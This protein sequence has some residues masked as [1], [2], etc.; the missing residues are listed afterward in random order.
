[1]L[2]AR[3]HSQT[4][5]KGIAPNHSSG[6]LKRDSLIAAYSH[7]KRFWNDPS[8]AITITF[9]EG[10]V[11]PEEVL[12]GHL[13]IRDPNSGFL[14]SP[15]RDA[16]PDGASPRTLEC[17]AEGLAVRV[18]GSRQPRAAMTSVHFHLSLTPRRR[19]ISARVPPPCPSHKHLYATM[20]V[21]STPALLPIFPAFLRVASSASGVSHGEMSFFLWASTIPRKFPHQHLT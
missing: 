10:G 7:S 17:F 5:S 13:R 15:N 6:W 8:H 16:H 18:E 2:A 3:S 9:I 20:P 12:G 11:Y 19:E 21:S 14:E 4:I 1:M